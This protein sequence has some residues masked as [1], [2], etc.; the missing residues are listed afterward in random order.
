LKDVL[1]D[2]PDFEEIISAG[3]SRADLRL[4]QGPS[5]ELYLLNKRNG[6]IYLATNTAAPPPELKRSKRSAKKR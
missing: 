4:G 5:G 6:W 3:K 2:E 1:D